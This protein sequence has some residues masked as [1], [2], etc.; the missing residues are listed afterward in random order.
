MKEEIV[1]EEE[2]P[3]QR[4]RE[5]VEKNKF[6]VW[7]VG[8]QPNGCYIHFLHPTVMPSDTGAFS[9]AWFSK[10]RLEVTARRFVDRFKEL[11]LDYCCENGEMCCRPHVNKW[12]DRI[13]LSVHAKFH[14]DI[15]NRFD[16]LLADVF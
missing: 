11:Y 4:L 8:V 14:K 7:A 3:C 16:R 10:G 5:I 15:F 13:L 12:D 2:Q 9:G 1:K 6:I